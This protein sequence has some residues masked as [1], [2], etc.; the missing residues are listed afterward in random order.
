M[1]EAQH[2]RQLINDDFARLTKPQHRQGIGDL[3]QG[4]Q[5][6]FQIGGVLPVAAHEQVEALLDPHQFFA[7]R[8][9]YRTHGIAVRTGQPRAFFIDHCAVG[10]RI[11]QSVA[12]FH[13]QHLPGG[14]FGLGN[15]EQQTLEQLG[16][17]WLID[18][19][20]ALFE[21]ALEF[22]VSILEQAAQ[23]RTVGDGATA[24]A[25]DQC[26]SDLP[27][28]AQR[29]VS[30]QAFETAEDFGQITEMGVVILLAQQAD[31]RHLQHLPQLAQHTWQFSRFQQR[32][33]FFRQ[34]R[35][36]RQLRTEQT[37]F[38]QPTLAPG[39]AQ[40][41]DQRQ[42]HQ[43]QI[44]AGALHAV[45]VNRQLPQ[46]LQHQVQRFVEVTD[47]AF[48]QRHDQ[49]FHFFGEQGRAVEFD[50]LQTAVNLMDARQAFAQ[51]VR[52]LR[53]IKLGFDR[54]MSLLQRFGNLAFDPFEGHIVV[55][56]T[57]NHSSSHFSQCAY[58]RGR[59]KL[60]PSLAP[61][62]PAR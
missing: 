26:R 33:G 3:S 62:W 16:W 61:W 9:Q 46:C 4:C 22:F 2:H 20:H 29:R 36:V 41:V 12:I 27:Q 53:V 28:R 55:P 50:H 8:G 23:R 44:T 57:H 21:Q 37:G 35:Q 58:A 11:V 30:A 19:V 6:A 52:R 39:T 40:I 34:R 24:H 59:F 5:Q 18:A 60:C 1:G 7:Q 47:A 14:V 54:V 51:G 38:R 48:L 43:R 15:V 10:Q 42:H 45:Q 31:Q 49:L 17:R 13:G 32:Q 56:I 25:F